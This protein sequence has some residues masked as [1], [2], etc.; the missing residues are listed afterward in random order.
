MNTLALR[1]LKTRRGAVA[2]LMALILPVLLLFC[3]IVVNIAYMQ[4]NR[5]ELR[6]ATDAA[7]RAA[8]RAFSE[9]QDIDVAIDYAVT[10]GALNNVGAKAFDLN[11]AVAP[12]ES[13]ASDEIT[14]GTSTRLGNGFGRYEFHP[15]DR[16]DVR[17]LVEKATAIRILGKRTS[18]SLGGS[19]QMLFAGW[20]PFSQFEPVVASTATQVDRDIALVLDRSG[21]MLEYKDLD[22]LDDLCYNLYLTGYISWSNYWYGGRKNQHIA[23]RYFRYSTSSSPWA[24]PRHYQL[25]NNGNQDAWEYAKDMMDRADRTYYGWYQYWSNDPAP[26]H[27]RWDQLEDAVGAFLDVLEDTD[28]EERVSVITFNSN[29]TQNLGLQPNFDVI[30]STVANIRPRDGT[31]ISAGLQSGLDSIINVPANPLSRPYA[32][33]TIVVMTDGTHTSGSTRPPTR[34]QSIVNSHNVIIHTVTF[35]PSVPQASKD[36]MAEVARIGGGKHYHADDGEELVA[37]F[38]EIA[39]NLPTIITE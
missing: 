32:A 30:R 29:A 33:K 9:F 21:S 28:Q 20:G 10:T 22:E 5:T 17:N 19:I 38:R 39:N 36:E 12:E 24:N 11:P 16:E 3:G 13:E 26:R 8:G 37:I 15:K 6:V 7:A 4:L 34:A 18:D 1:P 31:N 2:P 14:F 35:T 25:H 27:S 23:Y